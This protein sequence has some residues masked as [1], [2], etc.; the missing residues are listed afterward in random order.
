VNLDL[1]PMISKQQ[2][3]WY[4]AF[5]KFYMSYIPRSPSTTYKDLFD[6]YMK[7]LSSLRKRRKIYTRDLPIIR[8]CET[9]SVEE[10][11]LK[12]GVIAKLNSRVFKLE[13]II[14][15]LGRERKIL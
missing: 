13:A 10:I 9:T 7:K 11:R 2:T 6:D 1:T 14:K 5:R 15:V 8:R 4:M 12:D 3:F